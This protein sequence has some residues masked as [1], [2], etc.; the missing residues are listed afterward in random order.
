MIMEILT[1]SLVTALLVFL[2]RVS[3]ILYEALSMDFDFNRPWPNETVQTEQ[4]EV[5][6]L[7]NVQQE[8]VSEA[9]NRGLIAG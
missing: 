3:F 9:L 6:V 5:L 1:T 8:N 7:S 2:G 4:P